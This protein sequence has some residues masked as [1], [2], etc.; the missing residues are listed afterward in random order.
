MLTQNGSATIF[1]IVE[2]NFKIQIS[3]NGVPGK[4][5]VVAVI[6]IGASVLFVIVVVGTAVVFWFCS[7]HRKKRRPE[8]NAFE[9]ER[10][11]Q[12]E[13]LNEGEDY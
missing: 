11:M 1:A 2:E 9:Q 10:Y 13:V 7:Q 12:L 8:T 5:N 6:V 4:A 3:V